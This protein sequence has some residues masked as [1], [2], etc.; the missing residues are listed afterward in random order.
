MFTRA[1][2]LIDETRE[3][4]VGCVHQNLGSSGNGSAPR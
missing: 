3:H 2:H 4:G 1:G